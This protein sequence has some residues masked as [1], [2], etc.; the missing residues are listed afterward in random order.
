VAR[1]PGTPEA[2][3]YKIVGRCFRGKGLVNDVEFGGSEQ[4][5]WILMGHGEVEGV[6]DT[7]R[8]CSDGRGTV[9]S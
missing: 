6:I 4:A 8:D 9:A 2:P 5:M 3:S 7:N 1:D